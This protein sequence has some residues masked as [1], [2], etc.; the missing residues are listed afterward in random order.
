M[1]RAQ[2]A[3]EGLLRVFCGTTV[4][5]WK[6]AQWALLLSCRLFWD[7]TVAREALRCILRSHSGP[8][9]PRQSHSVV[10]R[11]FVIEDYGH[12]AQ[13]YHL[14]KT[15]RTCLGMLF[16]DHSGVFRGISGKHLPVLGQYSRVLSV[17][18]KKCHIE[19]RT[20]ILTGAASYTE[21]FVLLD[22]R[23]AGV[24]PLSVYGE[25]RYKKFLLGIFS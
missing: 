10:D 1:L 6:C 9:V 4:T 5:R 13:V 16:A 25:S 18:S 11:T 19:L 21:I 7:S 20:R 15:E 3:S 14:R 2:K 22:S 24:P 17:Y 8:I 23:Q 12:M